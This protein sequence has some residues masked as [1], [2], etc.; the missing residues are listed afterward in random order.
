VLALHLTE[1]VFL[2]VE[3]K[4]AERFD[5]GTHCNLSCHFDNLVCWEFRGAVPLR[6]PETV[7]QMQIVAGN[8]Y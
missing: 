4:F 5:D 6:D 8:A 7:R 3:G 1:R 2:L